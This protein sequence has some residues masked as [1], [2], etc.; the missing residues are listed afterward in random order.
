[1]INIGGDLRPTQKD[2]RDFKLGA[3]AKLEPAP[4]VDF[5]VY[6]PKQKDQGQT[7]RCA[8]YA[9]SSLVEAH[10]LVPVSADY[11]YGK[12]KEL[13]GDR[14]YGTELR[15]VLKAVTKFGAIEETEWQESLDDDQILDWWK[16]N[17]KYDPIAC[18]HRQKTY[19]KVTGTG[20]LFDQI[21]SSLWRFR[22]SRHIC[23]T[24]TLWYAD[25]TYS[26]IINSVWTNEIGGHAVQIIGQKIINGVPYLV[27]QN[28]YGP[29]VGENGR[30]YFSREVV[31]ACFKPYGVYMILDLTK[32]EAEALLKDT[33][34]TIMTKIVEV[35]KSLIGLLT[36]TK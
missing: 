31:N 25:W 17:E 5:L 23:L 1:M 27:I 28:S 3:I 8:G 36:K 12:A 26:K 19:F 20:D 34:I 32:E 29:T 7:Q 10:E 22:A 24:G 2:S 18:K 9:C 4:L 6:E 35:L 16:W 13:A 21:T 33:Q 15:N 14:G 11:I 30:H